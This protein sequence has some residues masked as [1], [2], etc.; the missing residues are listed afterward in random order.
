MNNYGIINYNYKLVNIVW[1][2]KGIKLMII[3]NI[4]KYYNKL[5]K[6]YIIIDNKDYRLFCRFM[7][8]ELI[9]KKF[10]IN[11]IDHTDNFY[12]KLF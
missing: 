11:N 4:L 6:K 8:P 9:F 12:F 5:K 7:F 3:Y 1:T 10:N 2:D